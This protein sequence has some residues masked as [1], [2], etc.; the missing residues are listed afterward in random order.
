MAITIR[1]GN[2]TFKPSPNIEFSTD[3]KRSDA[4]YMIGTVDKFVLNGVLFGSGEINTGVATANAQA[5]NSFNNL[6]IA[7]TGLKQ[8]L[9]KDYEVFE[10]V[11]DSTPTSPIYK[12]DGNVTLVD[13]FNFT[14]NTSNNWLQIV[15]YNVTISVYKTGTLADRAINYIQDSGYLVS[16]FVDTYSITTNNESYYKFSMSHIPP[17]FG[18]TY[19]LEMPSYAVSRN[20]SANGIESKNES[21]LNNAKKFV[22]G[23]I[24]SDMHGFQVMLSGLF[25]YDRATNINQ[26]PLNGTYG[27]D[28]TFIAYS[29]SSGWI[30]T[31]TVTNTTTIDGTFKRTIDIAGEVKGLTIYSKN[32]YELYNQIL[33]NTF[34]TN[35]LSNGYLTNSWTLASGGFYEYVHPNVLNKINRSWSNNTG[36]FKNLSGVTGCGTSFNVNP[37]PLSMSIKHDISKGSISYNYT[38]DNRPIQIYSGALEEELDINDFFSLRSYVFPDLFLRSPIAQDLGT[39]S[40][41]KR[42]ITY[43]AQIPIAA[44]CPIPDPFD[45]SNTT[46]INRN[47]QI[48]NL[49]ETFNPSGLRP[50]TSSV[51][52]GPRFFSRVVA[53]QESYELITGKYSYTIA[54]EYEKALFLNNPPFFN[55]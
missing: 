32:N 17:N 18:N 14:N 11:C 16:N 4:G 23:L 37:I 35:Q 30:D 47:N 55:P 20:I 48:K 15:D 27:I 49:I 39:Y 28:D 44:T 29:G 43:S 19:G 51:A 8:A 2:Y 22:S 7:L 10:V 46:N 38:Y 24:N 52:R 36:L 42:E 34:S 25:I 21:A 6:M 3:I 13:S 41:S 26:D 40:P 45:L 50:L 54:W 1:Y 53:N 5:N 12:S 9:E 33:D 31:Y